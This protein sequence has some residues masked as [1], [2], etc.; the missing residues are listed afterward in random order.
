MP[1]KEQ[2]RKADVKRK[3]AET[4]AQQLKEDVRSVDY[5]IQRARADGKED[6]VLAV[7]P[8]RRLIAALE[9]KL[10]ALADLKRDA[11]KQKKSLKQ[12]SGCVSS[13]LVSLDTLMKEPESFERGRKF[14]RIANILDR[15]NDEVRY[16]E[17]GVNYR[18]DKKKHDPLVSSQGYEACRAC[19]CPVPGSGNSQGKG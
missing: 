7:E 8:M 14:A 18:K 10:D 9:G 11:K 4:E 5:R 12:L 1:T 3:K 6:V 13:F 15:V 17:L 16:F 19:G 2:N